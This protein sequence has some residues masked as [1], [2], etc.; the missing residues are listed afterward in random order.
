MNWTF[1]TAAGEVGSIVDNKKTAYENL[2]LQTNISGGG[3][4]VEPGVYIY[5]GGHYTVKGIRKAKEISQN[6]KGSVKKEIET[7]SVVVNTPEYDTI[8]E[9]LIA[10][11]DRIKD[12]DNDEARKSLSSQWATGL[13]E[14][15]YE[16]A[17]AIENILNEYS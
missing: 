8:E 14:G 13:A 9:A 15:R 6:L 17:V 10:L 7:S 16:I 11:V 12:N 2:V 5:D 1:V 3:K 4:R